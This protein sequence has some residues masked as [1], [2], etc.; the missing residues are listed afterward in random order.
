[1]VRPRREGKTW[2]NPTSIP[3]VVMAG[4]TFY[5][6]FHY[7]LLYFKRRDHREYLTFALTCLVMSFYDT[8]CAGLY[9]AGSVQEG[10]PWQRLQIAT[11]SV[12]SLSFLWFISDYASYT[13]RNVLY[14]LSMVALPGAA[15]QLSDRSRLTWIA[16]QPCIK[17]IHLPFDLQ[18]VYHEAAPGPWTIF[19]VS[20]L[21]VGLVVY[22]LGACLHMYRTGQTE[23][24]R[25]LVPALLLLSVGLVND[26]GVNGHLWEFVY[27]LEYAYCGIVVLM[28]LSLARE[29]LEA[30]I[31]REALQ[32]REEEI[33]LLNEELEKR[34]VQR[35]RELETANR[36]LA[37]LNRQLQD[38][39]ARATDLADRAE[40]ASRA[41]S[42]FLANM[43]HEIRTPMNGVIGMTGLLLDTEL[44]PEQRDVAETI[45]LSADSLL[46]V[47]NDILD[48][49]KIEAGQLQLEILDFDLRTAVEDV[50]DMLALR[51]HEKGLEISCHVSQ[52]VPSRVR[53]DPGRIRQI[54]VNLTGNA[55]KFTE[56][57][58]VF[59]RVTLE[60][61]SG[62][63]VVVRFAVQDTGVGIPAEG[64]DRLFR[65][66][67]QVDASVSRRYG[68]TGLGLAIS[69]QLVEK[70][71]GRIGVESVEGSGS[72]FWFTIVLEKQAE[73]GSREESDCLA[74]GSEIRNQRVLLL[75]DHPSHRF[76]LGELLRSWGCRTEEAESG[77]GGLKLLR[78]AAAQGDPFRMALVDIHMAGMDGKTFGKKVKEDPAI[79]DSLLILLA[80]VGE[81]GD[82]A[83]AE[84]IG[85]PAY[86][87]KPVRK[88]QLYDCLA[89][90]LARK[91][92][93]RRRTRGEIVT[94]HR[95]AERQKHRMRILV[96]ED[97]AV[98]QKVAL[99]ILDRLGYRADAVGNGREALEALRKVPYDLVLMDV[100]MPEMDGF[101]ATR[102]IRE[103]GSGV[104]NPRVPIVAMTAHSMK[105]DREKCLDAGMDG[106]LSKPVSAAAIEE[107]LNQCLRPGAGSGRQGRFPESGA[108]K[109]VCVE[110]FEEIAPGGAAF[111]R[112]LIATFLA[113][114][115]KGLRGLE[116]A[117]ADRDGDRMRAQAHALKGSSAN[118]GATGLSRI[119]SRIEQMGE[120]ADFHSAVEML[121]ELKAGFEQVRR[122]LEDYAGGLGSSPER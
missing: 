84:K 87:T 50:I 59:V 39:T 72:T 95:L 86:L 93:G 24:A 4:I 23:K 69:K 5:L 110:R 36:D 58:E 45:R 6:G 64:R 9:D 109:A 114:A 88:S 48:F 105:G 8:C 35:T 2:M 12:C 76:V 120:S 43:S 16:D 90:V 92:E 73:E 34:V 52:E 77:S 119:A 67:S 55:I 40:A 37:L 102:R 18:V 28:A 29:V 21:G 99:R 108:E 46:S 118:A 47:I 103:P 61:E 91:T 30:A 27:L 115:E 79:R 65:S 63:R 62:N 17:E 22:V 96:A 85:F 38:A 56:R 111:Q 68:G 60:E 94:R 20:F 7:L 112:E 121:A 97:N 98:N 106:Y 104:C 83:E 107:A 80:S 14:G 75:D 13:R 82:S 74:S 66:F 53:G 33:R 116:S 25:S 32:R 78:E 15:F 49:S 100:Q 89:T 57:G 51:A 31:M 54:L 11:L 81:R 41:K 71:G 10:L 70:M 44:S 117:V 3:A 1:M 113:E 19:F 122:E 101:E 42:E 26:Y